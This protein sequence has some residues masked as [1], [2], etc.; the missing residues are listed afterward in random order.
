MFKERFFSALFLSRNLINSSMDIRDHYKVLH[1][2]QFDNELLKEQCQSITPEEWVA[3]TTT[4]DNW[5]TQRQAQNIFY[6]FSD[7]YDYEYNECKVLKEPITDLDKSVWDIGNQIKHDY[8]PRAKITKLLLS[9]MNAGAEI[10]IHID[11]EQLARIHRVHYVIKTNSSVS[12]IINNEWNY[13]EEGM[14]VEINNQKPHGVVNQG[15]ESRIHLICD[16]LT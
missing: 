16:I 7:W 15:K 12:F 5:G 2:I 9:K 14:C 11:Q 10:K 1:N 4:Q 8:G 6:V 13:F 3:N